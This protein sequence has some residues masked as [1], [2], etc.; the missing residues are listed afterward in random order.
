[1][2]IAHLA[3]EFGPRHQRRDRIDH[4]H[5]DGARADQ[6]VGDFERL[7]TRVGLRNQQIFDVDPELLGV[8][9][10]QRVLRIDERTGAARL[11]SFGDRMKRQGGFARAFGTINLDNSPARQP[12]DAKADIEPQ[13]PRGD[14]FDLDRILPLAELH[15][16]PFAECS[17]DLA[18]RRFQGFIFF[19]IV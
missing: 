7:L 3:L 11:L 17:L 4:Q 9:R 18:E 15:N 14:G 12:T 2:G 13:R 1:M 16:G 8:T 6:R 10:I 19:R 5:V